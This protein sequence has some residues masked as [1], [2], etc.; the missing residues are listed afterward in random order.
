V[1]GMVDRAPALDLNVMWQAAR[2][3]CTLSRLTAAAGVAQL[4]R[5]SNACML[6]SLRPVLRVRSAG[7]DLSL[8]RYDLMHGDSTLTV[9]EPE[10]FDVYCIELRRA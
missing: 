8:E 5:F 7:S 2:W 1:T 10:D 9:L 6:C 4:G 3:H